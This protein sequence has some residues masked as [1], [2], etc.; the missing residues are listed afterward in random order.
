MQGDPGHTVPQAQPQHLPTSWPA[1]SG[2]ACT[3]PG[4]G[5]PCRHPTVLPDL[6]VGII[7]ALLQR[8]AVSVTGAFS[9]A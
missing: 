8:V 4:R 6:P 3:P 1:P 9:K 2:A 5:L 7:I